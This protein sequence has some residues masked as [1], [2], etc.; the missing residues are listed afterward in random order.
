[1]LDMSTLIPL[2]AVFGIFTLTA[3]A[4]INCKAV[5]MEPNVISLRSS[6]SIPYV[7]MELNGGDWRG[8]VTHH[9]DLKIT[10][11]NENIVAVDQQAARLI[12]KVPGRVEIRVSFSECISI[13]VVGVVSR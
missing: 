2:A 4:G 8:E 5:W 11:S 12:G 9:P 13:A 10:S 3:N 7:V 1:M 6:E